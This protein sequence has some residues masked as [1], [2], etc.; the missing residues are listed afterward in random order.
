ML[1]RLGQ[2]ITSYPRRVLG[3]WGL[4]LVAALPFASRL[5]EVLTSDSGE[6]PGSVAARVAE[7]ASREFAT[8]NAQQLLLV[9]V[10]KGATS[11][12]EEEVE[13]AFE[14]TGSAGAGFEATIARVRRVPFV[15]SVIDY[16]DE[17]LLPLYRD[18]TYIAILN[19]NVAG[20]AEAREAM[21]T[22]QELLPRRGALTY[23]L[24]GGAAVERELQEIAKRDAR[25]AEIFG[26]PLSLVV[27]TV[28]FGAVVAAGL[29]L[30]VALLSI[31]LASAG[32]FFLGQLMPFATFAQT[33]VTMLGLATGIDYALLMVNRYREELRSGS[34]AREAA[35]TTT[36][37]A[38]KAV[39]SSGF[40]VLI[41][42]VSL[43]LPPLAFIQSIGIGGIAVML[44]SVLVSVTALP[45]CLVLLGPRVNALKLTRRDPGNRSQG[46]WRNRAHIVMKRPWLWTVGGVLLLLALSF[47]A[48]NMQVAVTG[49]RGLTDRTEVR[50][51]L[52]ILE[53][54]E[55]EGLL[56]SF[57]VLIDFEERGFYHP[58][59]VRAV[60]RFSRGAAELEGVEQTLSPTTTAGFPPLLLAQYYATPETAL[61]SP[62]A[63]LVRTTVSENGRYALLRV[64]PPG[65]I[66]PA[67]RQRLADRL[68]ELG[69]ELDVAATVGGGHV[70]EA[71]W[72][73]TLYRSFPLAIGFVYLAT[74]LLLCLALHSILL[75]LKAILLNTLTVGA[76]FG[77]ITLIFQYGFGAPLF[78]L[79]GGLGFVDTSVP[80]FIFAIVF[81]ISMD[82]EVFLV[83]RIIEGHKQGLS[84]RE[85][86]AEALSTTGNVITSAALIMFVVFAVFAFSEVVLIKSLSVGLSVAVIL[87]ATLVRLVLVPA[88]MLLAGR[89][90]WWLPR[91][92]AR[93]AKRV[94]MG[95]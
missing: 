92:V 24:S 22:L 59:S 73:R 6:A 27:L 3:V 37:T 88:M 47:P 39:V 33:V 45:A 78:G 28:A 51:V 57:D 7:V 53:E 48:L 29:P 40:T 72:T 31:T 32:L 90:N 81:G 95:H 26:L 35:I 12:A 16:R 56:R 79:S 58:S 80:F 89:W 86:V 93:I 9:A 23:L 34:D 66:L 21:R 14:E 67:E 74:F 65:D 68:V 1:T 77:V 25:R 30:L 62:F 60:S 50:Q 91:G 71:E 69:R 5:G 42:L 64:F 2:F 15:N 38:G 85:A 8:D 63:E 75:P 87:D 55:L 44:T 61:A 70:G 49:I 11:P 83:S 46:F 36:A 54:R 20:G 19:L 94:D 43:L 82:Y 76:A 41:A 84:D 13:E 10:P 4:I 52:N 17:T 18:G